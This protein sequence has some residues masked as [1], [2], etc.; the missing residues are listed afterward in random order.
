MGNYAALIF[1]FIIIFIQVKNFKDMCK[2]L[3]YTYTEEWKK[4][5]QT[6]MKT[7]QWS[8]TNA[9]LSESLKTGFF[10]TIADKKIN[11]FNRFR[12]F[13]TYL[14]GVVVV[15]QFIFAISV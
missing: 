14:M 6:G 15:L 2:Y 4:L 12:L 7:S 9:N 13:N 3:S 8:V 1:I 10:S 5:S 11:K